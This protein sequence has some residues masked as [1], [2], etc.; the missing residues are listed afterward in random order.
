[1]AKVSV[2]MGA[3]NCAETIEESIKSILDQTFSDWE[4][5]ICDDASDDNTFDIL[6]SIS[7]GSRKFIIL[8]NEKNLGLASS[9]NR[10][11]ERSSGEFLARQDADD[12]SYPERFREQLAFLERNRDVAVV[13]ACADLFSR[14]H[15][16]GKIIAPDNPK[17]IDWIKGFGV[18]HASVMMRKSSVLAVGMYDGKAVRLEDYDLWVRMIASG[19]KIRTLP[20]ILYAIRWDGAAYKRRK[21]KIRIA[22]IRVRLLSMMRLKAPPIFY[23]YSLKPLFI[24]LIPSFLIRIFH[25]YKFRNS[26]RKVL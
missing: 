1:M 12:F 17:L 8:R 22:E 7:A 14:G 20:G 6:K 19:N 18:I 11:I 24:A 15:V 26:E 2:I 21:V 16:W 9:L 3:H 25:F 4:C 13:G 5:L 10:C 23:L